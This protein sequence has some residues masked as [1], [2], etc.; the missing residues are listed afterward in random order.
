MIKSIVKWLKITRPQTLFAGF[1]PV[2]IGIIVASKTIDIN[3]IIA[4]ATFIGAM[5]IQILS[6]FVNDYYDYK[7]GLD[8]Q[9]RIGFKRALA[10]G[11]VSLNQMKIAIAIDLLVAAIVGLYLV[12]HGGIVILIIGVFS[13]LFAWLYTATKKSLSYLGI[14]DIFCF[15]FFGP[16]ATLGTT[17]LQTGEF[18][19]DSMFLGF[20]C[21]SLATCVLIVNNI[22]DRETDKL[23]NK[24]S[25]VV[26]FGKKAGEMEYLFFIILALVFSFMA[27]GLSFSN[28]IIVL[29]LLLFLQ[30][31]K[32]KGEQYNTMLIKTGLLNV[33]FVILSIIDLYIK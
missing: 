2:A 4:I 5:S 14:A 22:R 20:V 27:N 3:W 28:L 23:N 7:S 30:L 33:V 31:L 13:L 19:I 29:G 11:S 1:S 8:K 24:Q 26:R 9:G 18:S 6:N 25:F 12:I 15:I 21:G 16:V 10:E 32:A 17:A